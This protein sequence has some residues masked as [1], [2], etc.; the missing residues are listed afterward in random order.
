[1]RRSWSRS[2]SS[3]HSRSCSRRSSHTVA[4]TVAVAV[5]VVAPGHTGRDCAYEAGSLLCKLCWLLQTCFCK[6]LSIS[7][8]NPEVLDY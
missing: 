8:G 6:H 2:S 7:P 3:S 5:V 4:V 1:M